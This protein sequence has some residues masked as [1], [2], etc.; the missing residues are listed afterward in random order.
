M[1]P[2]RFRV[3]PQGC[4]AFMLPETRVSLGGNLTET[5]KK[6]GTIPPKTQRRKHVITVMFPQRFYVFT[7]GSS[8]GFLKFRPGLYWFYFI[9]AVAKSI[10]Y[11]KCVNIATYPIVVII[12]YDYRS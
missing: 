3:F 11:S 9:L 6:S 8:Y 12:T 1:F 10:N 5:Y 4:H 7:L 2:E